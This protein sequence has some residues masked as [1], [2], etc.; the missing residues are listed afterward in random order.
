MT[1]AKENHNN[2]KYVFIRKRKKKKKHL[3]TETGVACGLGRTATQVAYS[4]DATWVC[5]AWSCLSCISISSSSLSF[6]FF[7]SAFFLLFL[8]FG[9]L[10]IIIF[11]LEIEFW[12]LDFHVD[13]TWKKCHIRREQPIKIE[14]QKL[15]LGSINPRSV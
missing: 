15:D 3:E 11:G 12:R 10:I 4:L 7:L 2:R 1:T 8:H 5:A 9:S 6:F 14:S 13:I